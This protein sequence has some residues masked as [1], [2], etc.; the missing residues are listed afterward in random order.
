M[1]KAKESKVRNFEK[2]SLNDFL[3][4]GLCNKRENL[5]SNDY[6]SNWPQF[7]EFI[8]N[9]K[10]W[11]SNNILHFAIVCYTYFIGVA[12]LQRNDFDMQIFGCSEIVYDFVW[13]CSDGWRFGSLIFVQQKVRF[14]NKI[15]DFVQRA[16][17]LLCTE[18]FLCKNHL[19]FCR[20]TFFLCVEHHFLSI[21]NLILKVY[22]A[23]SIKYIGNTWSLI[24][25]K[26]TFVYLSRLLFCNHP[27][28]SLSFIINLKTLT[29]KIKNQKLHCLVLMTN[30]TL[31]LTTTTI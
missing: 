7:R 22:A 29:R 11:I 9:V 16:L 27:P 25:S 13:Y 8:V 18:S 26:M 28:T 5:T 19:L 6:S 4:D 14:V 30:G 31:I 24:T 12:A 17:N 10:C 21:N 15:D 2:N 20:K 3:L 1:N 23:H